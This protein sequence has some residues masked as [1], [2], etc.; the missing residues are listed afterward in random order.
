MEKI[1]GTF[2]AIAGFFTIFSTSIVF[3]SM[4]FAIGINLILSEGSQINLDNK[5]FRTIKS[6]F[7]IHIGIWKPCPEFEYLSVFKTKENQ[8]VNV[9]SATTTFTNQIILINLFYKQNKHITFYKT[10]DKTD[11]FKVAEHIKYALE[12]DILDATENE[13]KWL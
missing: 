10:N 9:M 5:T 4:F 1:F 11:A 2:I 13:S 12:I 6:I 7:G 3:G 8:T